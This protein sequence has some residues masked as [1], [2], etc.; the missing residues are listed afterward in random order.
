MKHQQHPFKPIKMGQ[1]HK[2]GTRGVNF[3]GVYNVKCSSQLLWETEKCAKSSYG[4][5]YFPLATC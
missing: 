3:V 1:N 5:V 2:A 4:Y